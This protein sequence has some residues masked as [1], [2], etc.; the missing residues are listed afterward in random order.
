MRVLVT[1]AA[2]FI[3]NAVVHRLLDH[4]DQVVGLDNLND[5]YDVGLKRARLARLD[6]FGAYEDLRVELS[7]NEDV[8]RVF[9]HFEPEVVIHLAAQAG[10]R[11]ASVDPHAYAMSNLVG[12]L[13]VL[14]G[15]RHFG[16]R[17][18]VF[19]SSSSVYG[20][21]R[22]M[23][24]SEHA[25]TEHPITFYGATKK[26]NE[27]MAHSY[28]YLFGLPCTGLRFFTVYGP[29]G[30]PDM[31]PMLF[32]RAIANDEPLKL[33]NGGHH[34]RSFTYIDDVAEAVVRVV[35]RPAMR[36]PQWDASAPDPATSSAPYRLFNVG[37]RDSIPLLRFVDALESSL[38]RVARRQLLPMQP[39]DVPD[40]A[41]ACADLEAEI[42]FSLRTP[43]EVGVPRFIEWYREYYS[44]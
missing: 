23:P 39:G 26:S 21:N 27:M 38:G 5:Y 33:F 40:T 9:A 34:K 37:N 11:H 41:A 22:A 20:G 15:C 4:G 29:W 19:A 2:G 12:F 28:A 43:I 18:L 8:A 42:G 17:H 16:V 10:V 1:G 30:R 35:Q 36:N 3:G 6:N 44:V 24:F 25:S 31:A 13:N 7:S 14:E 32:A